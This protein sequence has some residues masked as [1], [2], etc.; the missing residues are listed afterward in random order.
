GREFMTLLRKWVSDE[1]FGYP[2]SGEE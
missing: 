1:E 2:I